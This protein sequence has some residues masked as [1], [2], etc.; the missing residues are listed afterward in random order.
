ME[1]A[2]SGL[3]DVENVFCGLWISLWR[4]GVCQYQVLFGVGCA[5]MSV[6]CCSE[7]ASFS[8]IMYRTYL[9]I[10]I[11]LRR[12]WVGKEVVEEYFVRS[13]SMEFKEFL[14]STHSP[15]QSNNLMEGLEKRWKSN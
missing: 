11:S 8:F 3:D 9:P 10:N 13:D 12:E 6:V 4:W 14:A 15:L 7:M 5:G 1:C 2:T